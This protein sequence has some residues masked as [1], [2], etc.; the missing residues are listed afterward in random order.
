MDYINSIISVHPHI[1]KIIQTLD[2]DLGLEL[3]KFEQS[4]D[5][6][7]I[8]IADIVS[9]IP[10]RQNSSSSLVY[11]PN[12]SPEEEVISVASRLL[13]SPE[14]EEKSLLDLILTPWGIL[15]I[16][17]FCGTNFFIFVNQDTKIVVNNHHE[18]SQNI[19]KNNSS[20][21]ENN[22]NNIEGLS[23]SNP[24]ENN[25]PPLPIPL[26]ETINQSPYPNLKTALLKEISQ[27]SEETVLTASSL[28]EIKY[29]L[30][31]NYENID[32]FNRIKKFVSNAIIIKYNKEMKI[33]LGIFSNENEA[34]KQV[35]ELQTQGII[36]Q[37]ISL[38]ASTLE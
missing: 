28:K 15:G 30:V 2:L 1:K 29:Y 10:V 5:Q 11:Y 27:P 36:S 20:T 8:L 3:T 12:S 7:S 21:S 14:V 16:L 6:D 9:D 17:I 25:H 13:D 38:T 4:L 34:K 37:V 35:K 22:L 19:K 33:L 31:T 24:K 18:N 23:S 32:N 26:P